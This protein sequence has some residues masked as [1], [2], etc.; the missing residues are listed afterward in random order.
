MK[1]DKNLSDAEQQKFLSDFEKVWVCEFCL[2]HNSIPENYRPPK[3]ENP[4][5]ILKK[6]DKK[7][8]EAQIKNEEKV[9]IFCIDVSGSMDFQ[10]EGKSR[11]ESVQEA[12]AD[13]ISRFKFE[14]EAIKV[15]LITFG[16]YVT[17]IGDGHKFKQTRLDTSLYKNFEGLA[18]D[19]SKIN[20]FCY[21]VSTS[22]KSLKEV[23]GDLS[24]YGATALGPA[25]LS[26]VELASKG[27]IGSKVILCTDGEA[28]V[29]IGGSFSDDRFTFYERM[30][31]YA[32]EKKVMVNILS[33]KGDK[34]NL[35]ELGK[36]S[37]ATSGLVMKINPKALGTEFSKIIEEKIL[38]S[39]S[40]LVIK[41]NK[42]FQICNGRPG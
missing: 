17:L 4:C 14:K 12:I 29:G 22:F 30:A 27:G 37:Y 41:L 31:N 13:E 6:A 10:V 8:M 16:S 7:S 42:R 21:P 33:L 24:T 40:K 35:K 18:Q 38:G 11:L 5:T 15:G 1:E 20:N 19:V 9:L 2:H 36:L 34:C 23:V 32:K 28:N 39:E 25:L 26:A 3:E